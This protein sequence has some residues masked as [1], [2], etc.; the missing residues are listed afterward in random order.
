MQTLHSGNY[1]RAT[2][3]VNSN[4]QLAI[5]NLIEVHESSRNAIST[6]Y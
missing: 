4:Y 3:L 6:S 2:L 1:T 5:S